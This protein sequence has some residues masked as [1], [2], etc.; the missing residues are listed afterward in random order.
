M[1]RQRIV[2]NT[3]AQLSWQAVDQNGEPS[4]P[5]TTTVGVVGSDGSVILAPG[6]ATTA[7]AVATSRVVSVPAQ[8][9]DQLTVTW[10][11]ATAS[12]VTYVD[13]V[14]GVFFTSAQLRAQEPT[15]ASSSSYPLTAILDARQ[16]VETVF[17]QRTRTAFVP[18]FKVLETSTGRKVG[19]SGIRSVSWVQ[20]VDGTY[21]T[22][23]TVIA[24]AVEVSQ[25]GIEC[26]SNVDRVGVIFG[27]DTC[28]ADVA[29]VAMLYARHLLTASN[30]SG[31]DMRTLATSSPDGQV[32]MFPAPGRPRF[33][34]G[35]DDIDEALRAYMVK[36]PIRSARVALW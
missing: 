26:A 11:G 30:A 34:T 21:T 24:N 17:E 27:F 33:I 13:V 16:I 20:Y 25:P 35:I 36:P 6:T 10:S 23:A 1:A 15:V 12:A 2:A 19:R 29:R 5:G 7:G 8:S 14:G 31:I 18:R 9:V 32:T 22:D 3:A 4:D 28:P